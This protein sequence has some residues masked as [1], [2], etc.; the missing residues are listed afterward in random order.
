MIGN[1]VVRLL[2]AASLGVAGAAHAVPAQAPPRAALA[3]NVNAAQAAY[4]RWLADVVRIVQP[5]QVSMADLGNRASALPHSPNIIQTVAELR[6]RVLQ[7]I[8]LADAAE[9]QL[10]QL[11][12]PDIDQLSLPAELRTAA[13]KAAFLRLDRTIRD[14][15]RNYLPVLDAV[16]RR[17]FVAVR[18]ASAR[19]M[20]GM[21]EI[22]STQ[23]LIT[24]AQ[25][26]IM[27][28]TSSAWQ[29]TNVQ[30]QFLSAIQL[31]AGAMADAPAPAFA[32]NLRTIADELDVT[33]QR[34]GA[35]VEAEMAQNH[36]VLVQAQRE[37][38]VGLVAVAERGAAVLG[39]SSELFPLATQLANLLRAQAARFPARPS[40]AQVM[41]AIA[42]T[43]PIRDRL[44]AIN[45][46]MSGRLAEQH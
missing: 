12:E 35:T 44:V 42:E 17:D 46:A 45:A 34:G 24:R 14:S 30:V 10:I 3:T 25:Q 33:A 36:A 39:E 18:N 43:F 31:Y 23:L 38:N 28:P 40:P 21:Q 5:V 27:P 29:A 16:A 4:G 19:A 1:L 26:A 32:R 8:A 13:I 20:V 7:L 11:E 41:A 2:A 6:P 9:T 22:I 15:Y 37:G